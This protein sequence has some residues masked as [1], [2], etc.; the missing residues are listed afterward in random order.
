MTLDPTRWPPPLPIAH[1]GSRV[2]W[3]ENTMTAFEG[4]VKLGYRFL[5]TDL[6]LTADGTL[7][8]FHD[9]DVART[10]ESNGPISELTLDQ[11]KALDAG[12]RHQTEDGFDF[13]GKGISVPTL[14]EVVMSFPEVSLVVDMKAD[15][16]AGPLAGFV[17]DH[18]MHDRLIVGSFLDARISEFRELTDRRVATSSG[19]ALARMWVLASRVGRGASGE[20]SAL[21]L[22]THLRGVRVVDQKLV[23]AA[24]NSGLQV[25]VW[26]VNTRTEMESFLDMG[27]DGLV[28]DRPDILRDVLLSRGQ[29]TQ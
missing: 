29:W 20:A 17:D 19:P 26:T 27:V 28:T 6:R 14:A 8:C 2:L 10:T 3:P 11:V 22:P 1:R 23:D 7:V 12:Y 9:A 15:G 21:Q 24:H 16:L 18:Q 13:R 4:A 25:H 5:E